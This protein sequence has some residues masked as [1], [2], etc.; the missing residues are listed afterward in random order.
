MRE[1]SVN[2][3]AVAGTAEVTSR[4]F[5]PLLLIMFVGSGCSALIYEIVWFQLFELLIG[6]AT[7]SLGVLLGKFM[8]GMILRSC[9]FPTFLSPTPP[10]PPSSPPLSC[11]HHIH[12]L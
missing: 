7:V 2:E 12:V 6:S 1:M 8:V 3:A 5:L 11:L 9:F 4:R 10:P